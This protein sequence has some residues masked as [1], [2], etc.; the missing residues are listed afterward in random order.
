MG[1]C[2]VQTSL[3][4]LAN[5]RY[6]MGER[7]AR[8]L[9]M[10]RDRMDSDDVPLTHEFLSIMLGARRPGVTTALNASNSRALSQRAGV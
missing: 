2:K 7:P 5:G 9:L 3:T 1:N 4:T 8:W 6:K 10:A